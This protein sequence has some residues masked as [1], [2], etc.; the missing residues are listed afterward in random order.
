M[1]KFEIYS[2]HT[3][4]GICTVFEALYIVKPSHLLELIFVVF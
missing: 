1:A 4:N 3:G 2:P